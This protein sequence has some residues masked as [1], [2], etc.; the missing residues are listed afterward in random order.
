MSCKHDMSKINK[1][2]KHKTGFTKKPD[3]VCYLSLLQNNKNTATCNSTI[4]NQITLGP[5]NLL[6]TSI[7]PL[8]NDNE[9]TCYLG[10]SSSSVTLYDYQNP[11]QNNLYY[12]SVMTVYRL[13]KGNIGI[14]HSPQ[15]QKF[16][17][18]YG[19]PANDIEIAQI[20]FGTGEYL[21]CK[22]VVAI[23]TGDSTTKTIQIYFC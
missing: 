5:T 23:I 19:L 7:S 17:K 14:S 15:L 22:G 9:L 3:I 20:V 11:D 6:Q 2:I 8:Y 13:C 12:S 1:A 4:F 18:F 10:K 16:P 21:N